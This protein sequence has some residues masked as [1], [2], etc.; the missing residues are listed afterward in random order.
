MTGHILLVKP[1]QTKTE[2]EESSQGD[3]IGETR[4]ENEQPKAVI[5]DPPSDDKDDEQPAVEVCH[6][7]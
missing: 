2:E 4:D 7:A 5:E 6:F 3:G 1:C